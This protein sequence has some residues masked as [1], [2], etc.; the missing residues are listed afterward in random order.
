M[1]TRLTE[2]TCERAK[3]AKKTRLLYDA[4]AVGL[5]FK[6]T[7]HGRKIWVMQM[8]FPGRPNQT[9]R[10]LGFYPALGLKAAREKAALWYSLARQGIDPKK[11]SLRTEVATTQYGKHLWCVKTATADLLLRADRVECSNN[12]TAVFCREAAANT[13]TPDAL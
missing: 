2:K 9:R 6:I 1:P 3:A 8:I 11:Q 10:T 5:V 12:G 4:K 13:S 7:P